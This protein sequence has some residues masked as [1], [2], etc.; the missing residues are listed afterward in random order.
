MW[1][2]RAWIE[3]FPSKAAQERQNFPREIPRL[4][5]GHRVPVITG[6]CPVCGERWAPARVRRTDRYLKYSANTNQDTGPLTHAGIDYSFLWV[7]SISA[8][9]PG[10]SLHNLLDSWS[11]IPPTNLSLHPLRVLLP[12]QVETNISVCWLDVGTVRWCWSLMI[13]SGN[14]ANFTRNCRDWFFFFIAW[15]GNFAERVNLQ[16]QKG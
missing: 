16:F 5:G 4:S 8:I 12:R 9:Y 2:V 13:K 1:S 10:Q 6:H 14:S 15:G 7:M 11:V 3:C